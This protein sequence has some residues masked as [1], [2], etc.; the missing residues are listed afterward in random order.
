[1]C[2]DTGVSELGVMTHIEVSVQRTKNS[3]QR[4]EGREY[5]EYRHN[6]SVLS[7]TS[8]RILNVRFRLTQR[9]WR[10]R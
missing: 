9:K 10:K 2:S 6:S 5:I 3:N 1:M 4:L 7:S 8:N